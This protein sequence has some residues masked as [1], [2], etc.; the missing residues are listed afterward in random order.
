MK[1]I[2]SW[3]A[4][5]CCATHAFAQ[6]TTVTASSIKMAGVTVANGTVTFVP[7][8]R[9]T[10][11]AIAITVG[12]TLY[13][14]QGFTGVITNGAIVGPFSVPDACLAAPSVPNTAMVY[15]VLVFNK[16]TQRSF[17]L[18]N[19][20]G[21]CGAT[22]ALDSYVPTQGAPVTATGLLSGVTVPTHCTGTSI[23]YKQANPTSAYTCVG[24]VYISMGGG[25]NGAVSYTTLTPA[26]VSN[27]NLVG[28]GDSRMS[29]AAVSAGQGYLDY[30]M[31]QPQFSGRA[32][33]H[34]G[35]VGGATCANM[36][37]AYAANV[38]PYKP[39]GSITISYLFIE[40]GINDLNAGTS[41]AAIETC[42]ASYLTQ[43][44]SDGFTPVLNTVYYYL[45][46]TINQ[47][48]ERV[49]LN[50]WIRQQPY[51]IIDVD[52]LLPE[53]SGSILG[54]WYLVDNLHYNATGN[55]LWAQATNFLWGLGKSG[56][57]FYPLPTHDIFNT[58]NTGV[59]FNRQLFA[60][61]DITAAP[62][63]AS[64]NW[65]NSGLGFFHSWTNSTEGAYGMGQ[66]G[67]CYLFRNGGTTIIQNGCGPI[68]LD[69]VTTTRGLINGGT[70]F[71]VTSGCGTTTASAG[72][73]MGGMFKAG[74]AACAPVI[75]P[76]ITAPN[77]FSC[78][79]SDL[80]TA[81]VV[82]KQTASSTT[83]A[84]FG[85]VSGTAGGTDTINFGCVAY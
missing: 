38:L 22:W 5:V 47:D 36:T 26:P 75:T 51:Y 53:S 85:I 19:V 55:L 25:G 65:G 80:T 56:T 57:N 41:A 1:R 71:T 61:G 34:N 68:T 49:T 13:D 83:T 10:G 21:V 63:G 8:A 78:W 77:G 35:A 60:A 50:N 74:Q 20:Q 16:T 4:L 62:A 2:F 66:D 11:G 67:N 12:G 17:T 33:L 76:G 18:S 7:T 48:S 46:S 52:M 81:A 24:G 44:V 3:L 64:V 31:Q 45:S 43:A 72:G 79:M 40:V 27:V 14:G 9:T 39:A 28:A 42:L 82:M 73:A 37:S 54:G 70:T 29:G 58:P 23:F 30:L 59:Q 32:T 84:T 69:N 6:M 15:T